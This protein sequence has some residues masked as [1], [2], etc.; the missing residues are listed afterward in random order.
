MGPDY[1]LVSDN[2]LLALL[3]AGDRLAY[4]EIY[5]R[6]KIVLHTH[7]YKWM[8]DREEAKD[9][10]HE[11]FALLWDKRDSIEFSSSLSG[12]LYIS[13]RNRIFNRISKKK[14]ESK[15]I[16]SLQEFINK[17]DCVTDHRVRE[18]QLSEL[19]EKEIFAFPTKMR[20]V[21]EL[22]RK[23]NLS[24]KQIAEQLDLSE[25]T[26]RK[27]IQHA[28]RILKTKFGIIIFL[29]FLTP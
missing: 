21:F 5:N 16:D 25:Q 1:E 27:H 15:Y 7:A 22:S 20:L 3:K 11:I 8:R 29:F 6:Y 17:G 28:L 26:V 2:E 18:N 12:Y 19:I 23:L 9:I 4:T 24:H 13:L 10:I 14:F